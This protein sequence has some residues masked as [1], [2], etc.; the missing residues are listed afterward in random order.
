MVRLGAVP[1][2]GS[3]KILPI[4]FA[5]LCSDLKV[6]FSPSSKIM[7]QSSQK[8]PQ[9]ALKSVDLPAPFEPMMVTNSP[10]SSLRLSP[11]SAFISLGVE[12]ANTFTALVISNITV[13]PSFMN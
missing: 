10:S 1:F 13:T 8:L 3:W 7:P 2:I 5:L 4:T 6:I 12:G 11:L 9:I